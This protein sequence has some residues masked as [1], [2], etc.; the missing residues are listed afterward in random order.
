[1]PDTLSTPVRHKQPSLVLC[2]LLDLI[3]YATYIIPFFGELLDLIWAPTSAFIF[4]MMFG[5]WKGAIGGVFNFIEE[6]L[7]GTDFIPTFSIMWFVNY[8]RSRQSGPGSYTTNR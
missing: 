4:W 8:F 7:P 5:G 1:M 6:F 2:I 3:G